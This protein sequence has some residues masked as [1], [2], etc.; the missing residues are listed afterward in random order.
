MNWALGDIKGLLIS[1]EVTPWHYDAVRSPLPPPGVEVPGSKNMMIGHCF[2]LLQPKRRVVDETTLAKYW[3][4]LKEGRWVR[5]GGN[6]TLFLRV[7]HHSA[8][9]HGPPL[10]PCC[11]LWTGSSHGQ[12]LN[13][14]FT[15]YHTKVYCYIELR[16]QVKEEETEWNGKTGNNAFLAFIL[17]SV[18]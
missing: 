13:L 11:W 14:I 18:L 3:W 10:P 16:E 6:S 5:V 4:L 2:K 12:S 7:S 9:C 1:I 15:H 17:M 8:L